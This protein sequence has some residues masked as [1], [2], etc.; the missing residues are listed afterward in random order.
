MKHF[1]FSIVV[2]IILYH[3]IRIHLNT[4]LFKITLFSYETPNIN[5][6][7]NEKYIITDK[8]LGT[9][10]KRTKNQGTWMK[11][12]PKSLTPG[13][14]WAPLYE[15]LFCQFPT[16]GLRAELTLGVIF[17]KA[18]PCNLGAEPA[19]PAGGTEDRV[20]CT[21]GLF[22]GVICDRLAWRSGANKKCYVGQ[23]NMMEKSYLRLRG[24]WI[25]CGERV[26]WKWSVKYNNEK[27]VVCK[28]K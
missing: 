16:H 26:W 11:N 6:S 4:F 1:D 10:Q 12:Q 15:F 5:T 14:F 21:R 23:K 27:R 20:S 28:K 25:Q 8:T 18:T 2:I 9:H 22:T 17:C 19:Y 13:L 24:S 3:H 7:E